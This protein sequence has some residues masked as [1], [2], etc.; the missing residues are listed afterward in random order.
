MELVVLGSSGT[1]PVPDR[2]ASGYLIR[3]ESTTI[4]CDAGPGTFAALT[5]LMPPEDIDAVVLSHLHIDHCVDVFALLHYLAYGPPERSTT[6][7]IHAPALAAH[8]FEAFLQP[9]PD[10]A[11]YDVLRFHDAVPGE[12]AVV[13]DIAVDFAAAVH[14]VSAALTKFTADHRCL[15]YTGDTGPAPGLAALAS[16]AD[17]LLAEASL[18]PDDDPWPFHLTPA[19]A[20]EVAAAAGVGQLVLTHLRPTLE[21]ASAIAAAAAT[22]GREPLVAVP[23]MRLQI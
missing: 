16:G 1:Y 18:G 2:P 15:V 11:F 4:W 20:G 22:F 10:H 7:D 6:I 23:G 8:R 13:G 9:R 19:Q 21:P 14:S 5:A 12:T 3:T 17:V